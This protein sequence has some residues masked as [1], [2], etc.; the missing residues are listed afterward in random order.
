MMA[1]LQQIRDA[2]LDHLIAAGPYSRQ[3]VSACSFDVMEGTSACAIVFLPGADTSR[4]EIGLGAYDGQD[5][6]RWSIDGAIY[7]KDTGD[8]ALLL[9]R[10]WQAHDDFVQTMSTARTLNNLVANCNVTRLSF[11]PRSYVEAGGAD[12]AEI[13]WSLIIED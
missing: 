9:G 4:E 13:R 12:W 3:E 10:V 1:T 6:M 7:I 8:S 5:V 2:L 11:D